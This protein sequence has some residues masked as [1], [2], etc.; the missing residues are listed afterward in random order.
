LQ[1]NTTVNDGVWHHV[2]ATIAASGA[3]EIYIDGVRKNTGNAPVTTV[4]NYFFLLG[5]YNDA[6]GVD[7][8]NIIN[9]AG[10]MDDIRM[11]TRILYPEEFRILARRRAIAYEPAYRPIL[12]GETGG[13]G[14]VANPVLFH[15]YYMSQGM[16]P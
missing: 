1:S 13:G 12:F 14:G 16:R 4:Q 15:S 11:Y 8:G 9:F 3:C 7:S 5:K 6:S 10:Q 2:G